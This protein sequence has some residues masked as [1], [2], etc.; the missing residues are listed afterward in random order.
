MSPPLLVARDVVAGYAP[1]LPIVK[2]VS[3]EV[4][5]REIVT[6]IGPNGA[7]KSTFLKAL[8]GLVPVTSGEVRL[9]DAAVTGMDTHRLIAAGLA[10]VPQTGNVFTTLTIH[11]NLTVGGHTVGSALRRRLDA[12]YAM[13]PALAAKRG[14]KARVLSGGQ[15]QMLAIGRALMTEPSVIMLDEPTA[16]LAPRVVGEVFADLRRLAE[17]DVAV[18]MVEQNAKAALRISDRGYVLADGENRFAGAAA[19]LL[20]DPAVAE[21]FLGSRRAGAAGSEAGRAH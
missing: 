3:A 13:F 12:A 19:D 7:G 18:L 6:I 4:A 11:E 16:G 8:A 10:F 14:Q 9:G 15:R 5:R 17:S 21:A 2:G 1:G 20:A